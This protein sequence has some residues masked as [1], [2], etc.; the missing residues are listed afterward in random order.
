MLGVTGDG[1]NAE[2]GRLCCQGCSL[3]VGLGGSWLP[4]SSSTHDPTAASHG[5]NGMDGRQ[6][7]AAFTV[8]S[9]SQMPNIHE[10]K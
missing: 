7:N 5:E 2:R 6:H 10:Y 3:A 9:L 1:L 8:I 4:R